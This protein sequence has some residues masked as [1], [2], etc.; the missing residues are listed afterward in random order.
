M[1][2]SRSR[3]TDLQQRFL[4]AFAARTSAFFLTGGAVLAGWVLGHRRTD[5]LDLFTTD[6]AAMSDGE[7]VVRAAADDI[8]ANVESLQ[9]HPDFKRYLIQ[10]GAESIVVDLV[11]DRVPQLRPKID[12]DGLATDSAE[13]I[14]ANKICT[15]VS[16][17]E[18]RDLVDLYFLERAGFRVEDFLNDA[19]K[20]DGG[21]TPATIA[22]ILSGLVIPDS[23]PEGVDAATLGGFVRSLETRMRR[24]AIPDSDRS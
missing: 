15:L 17:S 11:R 16:R 19:R 23:L 13:E 21:V 18:I 12:R 1:A 9:T 7:R 14:M 22:W 8:G 10:G 5:D 20:K 24:L 3:L 4:R 2:S 6:D